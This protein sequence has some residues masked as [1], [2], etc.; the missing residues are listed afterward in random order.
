M[1]GRGYQNVDN[2]YAGGGGGG[3]GDRQ[4]VQAQRQVDEVVGIMRDNMEKVLDRDG[5]IGDLEDKSESLLQGA[6]QFN[7]SSKR[8]KRQM[9]WQDKQWMCYLILIV[10]VIITIIVIVQVRKH[11]KNNPSTSTAP[12]AF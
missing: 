4:L 10:S 1:S 12:P 9:W 7:K 3:T 6:T 8:L 2:G 5:K 11:K